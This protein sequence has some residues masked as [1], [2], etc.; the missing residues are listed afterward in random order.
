M[1]N[2]LVQQRCGH[3]CTPTAHHH[4]QRRVHDVVLEAPGATRGQCVREALRDALKVVGAEASDEQRL[5]GLRIGCATSRWHALIDLDRPRQRTIR[6]T[7]GHQA[8]EDLRVHLEAVL[9]RVG[10][11]DPEC[12]LEVA[13]SPVELDEDGDC[14]VGRRDLRGL[15]ISQH[16]LRQRAHL[17]VCTSI[18]D[19]VEQ[20]GVRLDAPAVH[21]AE[22]LKALL[23]VAPRAMALDQ[24]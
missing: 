17:L 9:R 24:R 6:D 20:H 8:S 2:D 4:Q 21:L 19:G 22:E 14:E 18:E 7:S 12:R 11:H 13:A 5:V 15:H 16:L 10:L 3:V 23:Q 1:P